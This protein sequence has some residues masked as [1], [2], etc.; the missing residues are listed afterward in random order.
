[1]FEVVAAGS[2]IQNHSF[3][4]KIV[5]PLGVPPTHFKRPGGL[6]CVCLH[7]CVFVVHLFN[8]F[9]FWGRV[10]DHFVPRAPRFL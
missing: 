8:R 7:A 3:S 9:G 5:I 1:M 6:A 10:F 2:L 4:V